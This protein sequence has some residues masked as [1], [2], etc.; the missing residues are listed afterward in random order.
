MWTVIK[1]DK[2]N[3][4]LLKKDLEIK[5][6]KDVLIYC[7]KLLIQKFKNNKL[8]NKEFNLLGD[9]MFCFHDKINEVGVIQKLKFSRGLK[10]FL[11]GFSKSQ[12]EINCFINKCREIEDDKGY[13]SQTVFKAEIN[14]FYKFSSGPFTDRIFKILEIQKSK[15][16]ILLGN[17][18]T[19]L[20][21]K[22]FLFNPI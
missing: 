5:L 8:I 20:D 11:E 7:P 12:K 9:Y 21:K 16:N 15:I 18:K 10:Y 17:I 6:G 3:I 14:K 13:I 19:T 2:K 4:G 22:E 1:F